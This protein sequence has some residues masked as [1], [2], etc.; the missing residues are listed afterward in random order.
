MKIFTSVQNL[1]RENNSTIS[2]CGKSETAQL[3]HATYSEDS[4]ALHG[5]DDAFLLCEWSVG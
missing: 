3:V 2:G 5:K 1:G 4:S